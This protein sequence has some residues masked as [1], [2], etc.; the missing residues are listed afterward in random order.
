MINVNCVDPDKT[1]R[2]VASDLGLLCLPMSLYGTLGLNGLIPYHMC[3]NIYKKNNIWLP[4]TDVSKTT[5]LVANRED[6][7]QTPRSVA[8]STLLSKACCF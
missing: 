4:K 6:P 8:G 7:D 1:P 3:P 5:K 2:F